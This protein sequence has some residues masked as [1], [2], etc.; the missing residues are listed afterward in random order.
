MHKMQINQAKIVVHISP[1]TPLL[2][3]SGM[4]SA[5]PSLPDMSFVRTYNATAGKE[6]VYIPGSSFK[7]VIRSYSEKILR[8][9]ELDCCNPLDMKKAYHKI[10]EPMG[11]CNK[12]LEDTKSQDA[13]QGSCYA[14]K[15][16]GSTAVAS[17]VRC[18]DG[19]PV[20]YEAVKTEQRMG[21]AIDRVLGSAMGGALFNAEVVTSGTFECEIF[22]T[23]FQLWQLGL[24]GLALRDLDEGYAQMGFAKSRGLG[25]V[26]ATIDSVEIIYTRKPD[27][28][29]LW[30]VGAFPNTGGDYGF[31]T[32]DSID[33]PATIT[34]E[35]KLM[36]TAYL[37]KNGTSESLFEAI[38]NEESKCWNA[39]LAKGA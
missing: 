25:R 12:K 28:G 13:Y 4:E 20:D 31:L 29:Q 26:N 33:I 34:P 14:C 38:I 9:L 30:G 36:R 23:N 11:S 2:I 6:T 18:V 7:G 8:T 10:N 17:R 22:L 27:E 15:M 35:T 24:I 1:K 19:H 39:F 32:P 21:V 37:W 3:K 5:D 16:Y